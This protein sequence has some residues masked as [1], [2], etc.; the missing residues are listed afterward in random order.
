MILH[1]ITLTNFKNIADAGLEFSPKVN[2]LLGDNGM[3][4][5]NLLDALY[6]L[7]F[8][9]SFSG[10][11]DAMLIRKGEE[12]AMVR[13]NYIRRDMPEEISASIRPGKRKSFRRG[14]KEYQRLSEHIGLFPL[15]MLSPADFQLVAGGAEERRR[16]IDQVISQNDRRYFDA[17]LRYNSALE[18]RNR[19]LKDHV[20]DHALFEAVELQMEMSADYLTRRRRESITRLEEIFNGYYRSISDRDE[21]AGLTYRS[22]LEE[23]GGS[24][25]DLLARTRHRD[26]MLRF[27]GAG[28]HRDEIEL[29]LDGMPARRCASQGQI[30]TFT[31]ALRFAQYDLMK[32]ALEIQ[33]LLLLDDIFDKLDSKRVSRIMSLVSRSDLFGQIF[34]TD[35]NRKHLDE[36]IAELPSETADSTDAYR[37]WSVDNGNFTRI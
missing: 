29:T 36:I 31:S 14:G 24:L 26:E 17:L 30:K 6:F 28:P 5:S 10:V 1:D 18:Q 35:T 33:P 20:Q 23:S 12:F 16:F 34:I 3:G 8:C 11:T 27:T 37:L 2:C 9:K 15:V 22:Q 25:S 13:G 32:E 21:T 19:L 7:S 4:K